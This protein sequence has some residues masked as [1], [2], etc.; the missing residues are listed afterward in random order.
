MRVLAWPARANRDLNPYNA[1]LYAALEQIGVQVLEW[2]GKF[3]DL[4]HVDVL[5]LHWPESPLN[6]PDPS[7]INL[8]L[9]AIRLARA[10]NVCVVWTAHNLKAHAG[11]HP[12]LEREFWTVFC[13]SLNGV[14]ALSN[15]SR[16][17]LLEKHSSLEHLPTTVIP[18]G[19]YRDVYPNTISQ[20][21]AR[22]KL[23]VPPEI[24]VLAFVGQVR[25]YKGIPELLAAFANLEGDTRL[26]IAGK[27]VPPEDA[28]HLE[29]LA[30]RDSRVHLELGFVPDD[31]LQLFLNAADL[32]VLP[33]RQILNSGSAL[34]ALSFNRSVLAPAIGS[35]P[36]LAQIVAGDWL[37]LFKGDLE[38][39][40]LRNALEVGQHLRGRVAPLE[41]FDWERIAENTKRFYLELTNR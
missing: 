25:A 23:N 35:L 12:V 18:H 37:Q 3:S 22:A 11:I 1:L 7:G 34:L 4:E 31:C 14:I 24:P 20:K 19:Y 5:H 40:H 30:A 15:H 32:I 26:L 36:E 29:T 9:E 39:N 27:P 17:A 41:P 38:A 6:L 21:E 33:Y 13:A 10:Q 16:A 2:T 8:V 28:P